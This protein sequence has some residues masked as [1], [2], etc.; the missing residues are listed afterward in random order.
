M[1]ACALVVEIPVL[2]KAKRKELRRIREGRPEICEKI[3]CQHHESIYR[4]L[5]YL[6]DGASLAEDLT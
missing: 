6:T 5:V 1:A 3:V 2:H 4:F